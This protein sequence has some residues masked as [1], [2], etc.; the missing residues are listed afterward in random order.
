MSFTLVLLA[1]GVGSRYGGPKQ[2]DP[3]GPGGGTLID[4]AAFDACR[5]GC[6]HIV[7]VVRADNEDAVRHAVAGGLQNHL[8]VDYVVQDAALP[9]GFRA[10]P[11]RAKPWGTG[12]AVVAA[13]PHVHGPFAVLNADDFYGAGSYRILAEWLRGDPPP[14]EHALVGFTLRSTLSPAG[15]VNRGV[16]RVGEGGF[17]RKIQEVLRI[18]SD[19]DDARYPEGGRFLPLAGDCPVS[20]NFWGF[21]PD[22]LP[23]FSRSVQRF[24][25]EHGRSPTAELFIPEVVQQLI[26]AGEVRVRVL[27]GGGPWAGLTHRED[28]AQ[29]VA[30]LAERTAAGEYPRELWT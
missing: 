5:V 4:Y 24:L 25:D 8:R 7:I 13:A 6:E 3:V 2:I 10:P 23:A 29:L 17:L 22:V 1:A 18:E 16:C 27:P 26:D 14:G 28:R 20:L 12:Q 19:G 11:G 9:A 15:P 21:A 30:V